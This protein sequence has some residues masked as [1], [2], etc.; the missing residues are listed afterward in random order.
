M[1]AEADDTLTP[2]YYAIHSEKVEVVQAMLDAGADVNVMWRAAK[3]YPTCALEFAH[4]FYDKGYGNKIAELLLAQGAKILVEPTPCI[5]PT[6]VER[7]NGMSAWDR[8]AHI[9]GEAALLFV[10]LDPVWS[11]P[12]VDEEFKSGREKLEKSGIDEIIIW[13]L[14]GWTLNAAIPFKDGCAVEGDGDEPDY[15][16]KQNNMHEAAARITELGLDHP[17]TREAIEKLY[18]SEEV[19]DVIR[20]IRP[21]APPIENK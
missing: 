14:P 21:F 4:T 6:Q 8:V 13:D 12:D 5:T 20:R 9:R 1:N 16:E 3:G 10:L 18:P 19:D 17:S 11:H 2:L 15:P 7:I